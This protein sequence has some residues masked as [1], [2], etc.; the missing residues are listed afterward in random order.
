MREIPVGQLLKTYKP[1]LGVRS[2]MAAAE[3]K[4]ASSEAEVKKSLDEIYADMR[5]YYGHPEWR[6]F[7]AVIYTTDTLLHQKKLEEEFRGVKADVNWTPII[8]V[9]KGGRGAKTVKAK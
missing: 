9:G 5:G 4:F 2:L 6:T 1:E 8:V 3:Y 7:F